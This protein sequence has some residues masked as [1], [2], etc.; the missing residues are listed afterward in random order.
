ML[1][2]GPRVIDNTIMKQI[3]NVFPLFNFHIQMLNPKKKHVA[4]IISILDRELCVELHIYHKHIFI[5]SLKKCEIS[6]TEILDKIYYLARSIPDIE[7][8]S[9][10]DE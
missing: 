9:L 8:I 10:R 3:K 1:K 4:E 2:N 7:F 6:G 5:S